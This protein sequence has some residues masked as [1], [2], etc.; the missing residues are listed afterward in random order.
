M[1]NEM[2]SS[3][4]TILEKCCKSFLW[5]FLRFTS[6]HVTICDFHGPTLPKSLFFSPN[7]KSV[8]HN[9]FWD[10]IGVACT[11]WGEIA[12]SLN[13]KYLYKTHCKSCKLLWAFKEYP[14][15]YKTHNS[16]LDL[17]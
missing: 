12:H 5:F 8:T 11:R 4:L 14:I 15:L 2:H 17:L 10:T 3:S 13:F 1:D 9:Y 6:M 16:S 7:L